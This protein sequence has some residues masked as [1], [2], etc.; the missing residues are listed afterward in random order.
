MIYAVNPEWRTHRCRDVTSDNDGL[1]VLIGG[2]VQQIRDKGRLIFLTIRDSQGICQ[3]TLHEKKIIPEVWQTCKELSL[4][5]VVSIK[6]TV[7]ADPRSRL[8]AELIPSM[9]HIHSKAA[10]KFPIDLTKKKTQMEIDT[11][12]R[13]R[14]LSI[15]D[16]EVVA[17]LE[18]KNVIARAIRN[19]F[20][21]KGFTEIFTPFILTTSTEGGAE[22]FELDYFG[23]PAVLAQ[24]CQFYKQAALACHEKVFGIIPSWRAEKSHTPKHITEFWQLENEIA[25][26]TEKEIIEVQEDLII[27]LLNYVQ[28]EGKTQL[29]LLNRKI[30]IPS[31]PFKRIPFSE[32]KKK[33]QELGVETD[34]N[35]DFG[36]PEETVLSQAFTDPFFITEFPTHLR[37]IYYSTDPENPEITLSLDLV[38]PEGFGELSSG[39]KRVSEY[40]L[41]KSRIEQAGYNLDDFQ[42]YL[43]MFKYGMPPHAGFGLGFERLIRWIANLAHI[44]EASMFPRT[45]EIFQP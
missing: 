40:K 10:L 5:S 15:R 18:L 8:G 27:Y 1:E 28:E 45:P 6:G 19:F 25:F 11:I 38:A 37:G 29:E 16:P 41:L 22:Q 21:D 3:V 42:W 4:E 17:V 2:F 39:G 43:R 24:S 14:E 35:T 44:R 30:T 33:L 31:K 34:P 9:I 20:Q 36:A 7:K 26:A 32:A 13:Y 12:F 23:H